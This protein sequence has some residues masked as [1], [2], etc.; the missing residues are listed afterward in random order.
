M[1]DLIRWN[2]FD[3]VTS[4]RCDF[5]RVLGRGGT[6]AG[7]DWVPSVEVVSSPEAWTITAALPGVDPDDVHVELD[8]NVLTIRG[9]RRAHGENPET[10]VSEFRYGNFERRFAVPDNIDTEQ[11]SARFENGMLTLTL[12]LTA[13]AKP[14][15]I[16]VLNAAKA[17]AA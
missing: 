9:E 6:L 11:V 12:P 16:A 17:R 14:R 7:W 13:A 8:R 5:D 10:H 1:L 15:R 4:L 3:D 2:P